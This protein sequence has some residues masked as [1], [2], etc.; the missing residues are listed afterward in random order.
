MLTKVPSSPRV[1]VSAALMTDDIGMP[2]STI[3][4]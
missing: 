4:W 3:V 1:L 2:V